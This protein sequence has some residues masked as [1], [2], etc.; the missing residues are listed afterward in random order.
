MADVLRCRVR[1]FTDGVAV[2][3]KAF[4]ADVLSPGRD[5][6]EVTGAELGGLAVAS[7]LR[8]A[9]ICAPG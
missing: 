3:S 5:P 1:Y 7:R 6:T 4:L 9:A 8:D 2:G